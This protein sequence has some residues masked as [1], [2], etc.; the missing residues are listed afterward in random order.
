MNISS[1]I[2]PLGL[3]FFFVRALHR[4]TASSTLYIQNSAILGVFLASMMRA[5]PSGAAQCAAIEDAEFTFYGWPDHGPP[6]D[7][8]N[9]FNGGRG[10]GPDGELVVRGKSPTFQITS[11]GL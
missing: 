1:F 7:P 8:D 2:N 3:H 10:I 4:L 11:S 6:L 9:A 5:I